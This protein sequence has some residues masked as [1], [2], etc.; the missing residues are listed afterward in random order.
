MNL[1]P[2]ILML[3]FKIFSNKPPV[4]FVWGCDIGWRVDVT[5]PP[6]EH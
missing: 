6:P 2:L 3:E 5:H 1:S 4:S